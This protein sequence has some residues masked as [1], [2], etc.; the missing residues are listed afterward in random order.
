LIQ[1]KNIP[2]VPSKVDPNKKQARSSNDK[3]GENPF[4]Y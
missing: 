1:E 4:F 2:M 3:D